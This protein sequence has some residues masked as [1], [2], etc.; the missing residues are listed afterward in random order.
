MKPVNSA[1]S[2]SPHRRTDIAPW[3]AKSMLDRAYNEIKYRI[4]TC[5]YRPAEILSETAISF[6]L[7]IGRTPV[8]QAI[9]QLMTE[10]LVCII[11]RKGLMVHP[12][13][14]DE[15]LQILA[16]RLVT[17]CYCAHLA[18][19]RAD[20]LDLKE[21]HTIIDL[22]AKAVARRDVEQ[23][24]LLDKRFHHALACAARNTVLADILRNLHERSLRF[25]FI[26]LHGPDRQHDILAQHRAIAKAIESRQPDAASAAMREHILSSQRNVTSSELDSPVTISPLT[27]T[28]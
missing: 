19:E 23:M 27:V 21:L 25:W 16:V 4:I 24:M 10:G 28:V 17:E 22:S 26:L 1:H 15:A 3:P 11:P 2:K 7:G 20:D 9:H 14:V 8:H 12:V 13:S 6:E 5:R 18:A